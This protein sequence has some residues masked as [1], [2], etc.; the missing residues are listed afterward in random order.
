MHIDVYTGVHPLYIMCPKNTPSV[1]NLSL[2]LQDVPGISE[3]Y[4]LTNKKIAWNVYHEDIKVNPEFDDT[5]DVYTEYIIDVDAGKTYE[6]LMTNG[7]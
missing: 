2:P 6:L 7:L 1:S 5:E 4:P 3:L